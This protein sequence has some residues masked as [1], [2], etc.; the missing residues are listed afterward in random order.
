MCIGLYLNL[1]EEG[2]SCQ[3]ALHVENLPKQEAKLQKI[4][5]WV[6]FKR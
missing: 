5:C 6:F 2:I 4:T 3:T 1:K